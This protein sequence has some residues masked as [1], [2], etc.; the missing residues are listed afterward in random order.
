MKFMHENIG[1]EHRC[2]ICNKVSTN[3]RALRRHI[4]LNHECERKYKCHMCEKAFKREQDLRVSYTTTYNT[5]LKKDLI[6]N[7]SIAY[8]H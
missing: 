7:F 5:Q 6:I 8:Y 3:A 1:G 4:Y 2:N